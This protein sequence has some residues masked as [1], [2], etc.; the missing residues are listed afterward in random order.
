MTLDNE[1]N[2]QQDFWPAGGPDPPGQESTAD[3]SCDHRRSSPVP[4]ADRMRPLTFDEFVGQEHIVGP[5]TMLRQTIMEDRLLSFILWGPPGSGKTTL[6]R[7]IAHGTAHHY[8]EMSAVTTGI[9]EVRKVIA[10]AKERLKATGRR[11]ILFIDEIHRFNKAQQDAFLPH[12]EAGTIILIG[13]TTE[14][15]FFEVITPLTSRA[16]VYQ[17]KTLT[18]EQV[19]MI[20]DRTLREG[21]RGLGNDSI[22][23][24]DEARDFIIQS[25]NGDARQALGALELAVLGTARSE[26]GIKHISLQAASDA[27]QRQ[28]L[29]Y[30]KGADEHYDT[31][32]AFIKSI[33]GSDPDAALYW[34]AR[35]IAAGEDPGFI[36]RRMIIAAAEDVGNA[37]PFA[38][39]VANAAAQ[40]VDCV[41]MPEARIPLA[42]AATY[43]ACAPKSNAAY[44]GIHKALADVEGKARLPVPAHLR[45][46]AFARA[47]EF[48][49]GQGYRYAHEFTGHFIF[50]QYLPDNLK[51]TIYYEPGDLGHEARQKERLKTW[52]PEKRGNA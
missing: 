2:E 4:L 49:I 16:R 21:E 42:Q 3:S 30:D 15:P 28:V 17:L 32:S 27:L 41:G 37:D 14:N 26:D 48:G 5:G 29:R 46:P 52:W 36:A 7:I 24:D 25:A 19:G 31:V 10:A 8:L 18:H 43:L 44:M 39:L 11:T 20:I 47:R 12:V 6:A 9:P 51:D 40:A 1:H 22:E 38:L 34:M 13:A 23:L 45:N 35:M 50:Q 33:R